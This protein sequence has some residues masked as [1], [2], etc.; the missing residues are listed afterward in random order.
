MI[1]KKIKTL[2]GNLIA[3]Q[4]R[5]IDKALSLNTD[6]ELQYQD[7]KMIVPKSQLMNPIKTSIVPDKFTGQPNRLYYFEWKPKDKRQGE[8]I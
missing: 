4:G 8:L 5:Y 7:N 6:L 1:K 2:F 3:V